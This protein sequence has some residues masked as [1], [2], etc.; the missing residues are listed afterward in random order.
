M[1]RWNPLEDNQLDYVDTLSQTFISPLSTTLQQE[2]VDYS[3]KRKEIYT[4]PVFK[5]SSSDYSLT[6]L[7]DTTIYDDFNTPSPVDIRQQRHSMM[8]TGSKQYNMFMNERNKIQQ[9]AYQLNN[10]NNIGYPSSSSGFPMSAPATYDIQLNSQSSTS[11]KQ[12]SFTDLTQHLD[13]EYAMQVNL[14][15]MM[16]KRRRRRESHNAVERRRRENINDR[17][18]ELGCLLPESMLDEITHGP[19]SPSASPSG[20]HNTTATKPNKG[21]IL[22]KSVDHIRLLQQDVKRYQ[23]RVKDLE[24]ML[25]Q[26]NGV[27]L[28]N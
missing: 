12:P 8:A 7:G 24:L 19:H 20:S 2:T 5:E 27:K 9:S 15:A 23:Q 28:E 25:T 14:Q 4:A 21:A 16:E 18:H 13:D 11:P 26:Y 3:A 6:S 10:N 22:R 17:I 1:N